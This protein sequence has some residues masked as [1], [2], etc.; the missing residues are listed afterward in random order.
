MLEIERNEK[1]RERYDNRYNKCF[2]ILAAYISETRS[3]VEGELKYL[4]AKERRQGGEL[5]GKYETYH[6]R[7]KNFVYMV[8]EV[9]GNEGQKEL[10]KYLADYPTMDCKKLAKRIFE[11]SEYWL[12]YDEEL[13]N[14]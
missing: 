13:G 3:G 2:C 9:F 8:T 14:T 7:H 6:T 12:G 4:K 10:Y 5:P 1:N 11:E